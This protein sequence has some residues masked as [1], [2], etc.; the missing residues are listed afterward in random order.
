MEAA[1]QFATVVENLEQLNREKNN[2]EGAA[3]GQPGFQDY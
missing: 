3:Q 2:A 1:M